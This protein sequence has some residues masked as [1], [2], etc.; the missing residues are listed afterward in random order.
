MRPRAP[1]ADMRQ[2]R[3]RGPQAPSA[4]DGSTYLW[5]LEAVAASSRCAMAPTHPRAL[6]ARP[7]DLAASLG[8][9]RGPRALP[10][11]LACG[12]DQARV[13]GGRLGRAARPRG[14]IGGFGGGPALG[15]LATEP[16]WDLRDR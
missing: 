11:R 1:S 7:R 9:R 8:V 13:L 16:A 4:A 5:S 12:E 14:P 3:R 2:A 10:D 6:G 15:H